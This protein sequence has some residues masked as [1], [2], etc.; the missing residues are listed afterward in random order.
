MRVDSWAGGL[1]SAVVLGIAVVA[2]DIRSS[3]SS[4][5]LAIEGGVL[6]EEQTFE[7]AVWADLTMRSPD[8]I[9]AI[10]NE[11][12]ASLSEFCRFADARFGGCLVRKFRS[13]QSDDSL[14]QKE[15]E[16]VVA[17]G[18]AV[19]SAPDSESHSTRV[20]VRLVDQFYGTFIERGVRDHDL[21]RDSDFGRTEILDHRSRGFLRVCRLIQGRS[22]RGH[23]LLEERV[24]GEAEYDTK[25]KNDAADQ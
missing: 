21:S 9:P 18:V 5:V 25:E 3:R 14:F 2:D 13:G 16:S 1:L 20:L 8:G 10:I 23:L 12:V 4:N 6:G 7:I 11:V 24:G 15:Q 17:N 22:G 19:V